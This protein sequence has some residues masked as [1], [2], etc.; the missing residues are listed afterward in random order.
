MMTTVGLGSTRPLANK[1]TDKKTIKSVRNKGEGFLISYLL[2]KVRVG[3]FGGIDG[4][5]TF[6]L[7]VVFL[8][9][10]WGGVYDMILYYIV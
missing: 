3:N 8:I 2:K 4:K 9:A 1:K 10:V 5:G 7:I 6:F